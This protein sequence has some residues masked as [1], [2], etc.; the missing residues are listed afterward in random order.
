MDR[1]S[2]EGGTSVGRVCIVTGE[3]AGP[4]YN[5]GIGTANRGLALALQNAGFSVDVLYTRVEGG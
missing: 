4:D 5:G 1:P 2:P 3:M